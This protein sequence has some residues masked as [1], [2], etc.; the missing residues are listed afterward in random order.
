MPSIF[1]SLKSFV[2]FGPSQDSGWIEPPDLQTLLATDPAPLLL[3]VR[4]PS[5][6]HGPLGHID[7]AENIPLDQIPAQ[8]AEILAQNRPIVCI[9][10]TDRRS[11]AAAT[12]LRSA[13]VKE[14][15]VLRGGMVGWRGLG[16]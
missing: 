7:G 12:H 15:A 6:Y 1:S 11:A 14:V 3:D 10:H 16:L 8:T 4:G 9:C 2:G 13:G 5:E